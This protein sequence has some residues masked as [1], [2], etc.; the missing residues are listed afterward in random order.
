MRFATPVPKG[1]E[2]MSREAFKSFVHN[3][4]MEAG[5]QAKLI[6][7]APTKASAAD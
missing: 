7:I 4:D 3:I 2:A 5:D 6:P 1:P